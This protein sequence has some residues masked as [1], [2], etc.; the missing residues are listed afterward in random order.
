[1]GELLHCGLKCSGGL[2]RALLH[3]YSRAYGHVVYR[4]W[5]RVHAITITYISLLFFSEMEGI[6][7]YTLLFEAAFM[8]QYVVVR[9]CPEKCY[10][11]LIG[12][13]QPPILLVCLIKGH[14]GALKVRKQLRVQL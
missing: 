5:T 12:I 1:M 11:T 8:L 6:R 10:D 2:S 14:Q 4:F 13:V 7:K 9:A 3:L